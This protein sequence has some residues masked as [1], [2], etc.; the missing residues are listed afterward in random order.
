MQKV[1][2]ANLH[3]FFCCCYK[4]C[5]NGCYCLANQQNYTSQTQ[6]RFSWNK[7]KYVHSYHFSARASKKIQ[8][9]DLL[10]N[11]KF[12]D[13]ALE[14]VLELEKLSQVLHLFHWVQERRVDEGWAQD[15]DADAVVALGGRVLWQEHKFSLW[16]FNSVQHCRPCECVS[17]RYRSS[18]ANHAMFSGSVDGLMGGMQEGCGGKRREGE[19]TSS[20]A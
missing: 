4:T 9:F 19:K 10:Q 13:F 16:I 18:E 11:S 12:V 6:K 17:Y 15:V 20:S 1:L 2:I 8:I 7:N 14:I 5:L 3:V